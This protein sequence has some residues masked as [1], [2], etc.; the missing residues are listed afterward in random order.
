M[1]IVFDSDVSASLSWSYSCDVTCCAS[2][3]LQCEVISHNAGSI[4]SRKFRRRIVAENVIR[5]FL[6]PQFAARP[7]AV[8]ARSLAF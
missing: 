4:V 5:F 8:A 1:P 7:I 3:I 2:L 6:M